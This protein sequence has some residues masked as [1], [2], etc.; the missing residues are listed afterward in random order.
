[1][2]SAVVLVLVAGLLSVAHPAYAAVPA[3]D[4]PG[5]AV[6]ITSLPFTFSESTV[7]A[8][9]SA[10]EAALQPICGAPTVEHGVWFTV[11]PTED[12][13]AIADVTQSDY[14]AGIMVFNGSPSSSTFLACGPGTLS[15]PVEAGATY[16]LL[17][18]GDGLTPQ[19]SGNLVLQVRETPPPPTVTATVAKVGTVDKSGA[20]HISGT[21]TCSST[22]N[23]GN[24]SDVFGSLR[25]TVGRIF[26]DGTF[27]AVIDAPCDGT[28]TAWQAVVVGTNGKF[29][30]GKA[31][32]ITTAFGC[33]DNGCNQAYLETTIQLRHRHKG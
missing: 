22:D 31:A 21:I 18:F 5:G 2:R 11:T 19:T 1:M 25:Q 29:S 24:V 20:A 10:D 30:G 16:Y 4:D 13:S 33:N 32:N 28:V 26:I 27:D 6:A 17:V 15:G 9:T 23:S 7:D 12:V 8:T 3:N 14:S